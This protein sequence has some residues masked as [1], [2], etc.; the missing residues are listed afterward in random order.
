MTVG[1]DTLL[2]IFVLGNSIVPVYSAR[3]V[4]LALTPI[5]QS[6]QQE[7]DINGVLTDLSL[8]QF[9]KYAIKVS[10][11]DQ[12]VPAIDGIWPGTPVVLWSCEELSYP[13]GG[14]P[15]RS[16]VSGSSRVEQGFVFYRPIFTAMFLGH[17]SQ[18]EEW[19]ADIA[20]SYDLEEI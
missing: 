8:A 3:G 19:R 13:I 17:S 18:L 20:W 11:T 7:R 14:T 5:K 16:E 6:Q 1:N 4:T 15:Q 12:R 10:C 9:H 2:Q